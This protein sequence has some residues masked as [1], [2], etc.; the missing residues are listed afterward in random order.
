MKILYILFTFCFSIS[1]LF[2][3][4]QDGKIDSS[5]GV[6]GFAEGVFDHGNDYGRAVAIQHDGKIIV[7]GYS[8]HGGFYQIAL[9]RYRTNGSVDSSFGTNGIFFPPGGASIY[10]L[11]TLTLALQRD[12]KILISGRDDPGGYPS[13][14]TIERLDTNGT[15]DPS[16]GAQGIVYNFNRGIIRSVAVQSDGKILLA[17]EYSG[18]NHYDT[19]YLTRYDSNGVI[20]AS[21]GNKGAVK[22]TFESRSYTLKILADGK[23]LVSGVKQDIYYGRFFA[24]MRFQSNGRIDS[25]FGNNGTDTTTFKS[26]DARA[27]SMY[28]QPDERIIQGGYAI[29]GPNSEF[30]MV[31][32]NKDGSVDKT[33]GKKGIVLTKIG[34]SCQI[35]SLT[36]QTDG[37]IIAAGYTSVSGVRRF[38]IVRYT[39]DGLIDTTFGKSGIDIFSFGISDDVA[40][41]VVLQNDGKLIAAGYSYNGS[42]YNFALLRCDTSGSIDSAFNVNGKVTTQIGTG[43]VGIS[44][45]LV[46]PDGKILLSGTTSTG[47]DDLGTNQPYTKIAIARLNSDGSPDTGFQTGGKVFGQYIPGNGNF[48]LGLQST[49][50]IIQGALL[51]NYN[52]NVFA[53]IRYNANGT[54]DSSF[55]ELGLVTMNVTNGINSFIVLPNDKIL[56]AANTFQ[57]GNP[58]SM[59]LRYTSD[60]SPDKSFD[61]SQN[62]L[63][64]DT[65]GDLLNILC[66]TIL[67]DGKI[68]IA[69][70]VGFSNNGLMRLDSNGLRDSTFG[71]NGVVIQPYKK[72]EIM[73][74]ILIKES[75]GKIILLSN[76]FSSVGAGDS[77]NLVEYTS[78][79]LQDTDFGS[80][81]ELI[82]PFEY[83]YGNSLVI[84]NDQKILVAASYSDRI[85][86]RINANGTIDSTF[87]SNG[88]V[89]AFNNAILNLF[90]YEKWF[91]NLQPDGSI[92]AS[93][94]FEQLFVSERF[95][96]NLSL[97]II[98]FSSPNNSVLVYPN[99]IHQTAT[100]KYSFTENENITINLYDVSG[101]VVKT[102]VAGQ[103]QAKGNYSEQINF[104]S[105]IPAGDYFLVISNGKQKETVELIKQ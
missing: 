70:I 53:L 38:V 14:I 31:R 61:F 6:Y 57:N 56:I 101:R 22:S 35:H 13:Y 76:E 23:F 100:L 72:N 99:P 21:F 80:A 55:G 73:P 68:L 79:G 8:W 18:I 47:A 96:N 20:D 2:S 67:T 41:S 60:G 1:V 98:N 74:W 59:L 84:Q 17:G 90:G 30:A 49:G 43:T 66:A 24:L 81:G 11:Q 94:G 65:S 95:L 45:S 88:I 19:M 92:I 46:Q 9:V 51:S 83:F 3:F 39:T 87:G 26:F 82:L 27:F 93:T 85:I 4:G 78:E 58:I 105:N 28:V 103:N 40:E 32:Y 54:I 71:I 15:P 29:K 97:G 44:Y 12:G 48:F 89:L 86:I 16:F 102:F 77:I 62:E 63:I 34:D 5:F 75:N 104:E 69:G 37:K 33:F 7:A 50:K 36:G 42:V 10:H 52:P 91:L 64:A 25:S